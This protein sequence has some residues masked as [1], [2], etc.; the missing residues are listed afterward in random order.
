MGVDDATIDP[1]ETAGAPARTGVVA[2]DVPVFPVPGWERYQ[3]VRFLGQGG[4]GRVFLALDP[5]L[6]REVAIK[7][8]RGDDPDLSRRLVQEARAQARVHHERVCKVHDEPFT[9]HAP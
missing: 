7:L 9:R 2:T 1:F 8:V 6:H 4:M 3:P 5:R